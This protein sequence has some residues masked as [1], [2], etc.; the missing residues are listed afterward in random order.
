ME[1]RFFL[2]GIA[3]H[4]CG[5]SPGNVESPAAIEADFAYAW[6]ALGDWTTVAAGE[7]ADAFIGQLFV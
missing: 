2:D 3:L 4:T 7:A 5:V 6:L 1:K